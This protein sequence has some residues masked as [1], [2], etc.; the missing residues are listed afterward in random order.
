MSIKPD[1]TY[2]PEQAVEDGV[3]VPA[4]LAKEAGFGYPV[5]IGDGLFQEL[6]PT[7]EAKKWSKSWEG[8]QWELLMVVRMLVARAGDGAPGLDSD[9]L[10]G[11]VV[12]SNDAKT[13]QT[14][15]FWVG[16]QPMSDGSPA[17]IVFRPEDR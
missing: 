10:E 8:R 4:E 12:I 2:T 9:Y 16:I 6:Q 17:I 11:E 5:Y 14:I 15:D 13:E 7:E 1:F 3:Y